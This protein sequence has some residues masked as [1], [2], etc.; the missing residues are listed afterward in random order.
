MNFFMDSW[1]YTE[2]RKDRQ[3]LEQEKKAKSKEGAEE[4][5]SKTM[6]WQVVGEKKP[7]VPTMNGVANTAFESDH[8]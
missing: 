1:L 8:L 4:N 7:E 6:K 2:H 3:L 5:D